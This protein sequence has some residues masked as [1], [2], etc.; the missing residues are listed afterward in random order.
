[1]TTQSAIHD[2]T[3]PLCTTDSEYKTAGPGWRHYVCTTCGNFNISDRAQE[4]IGKLHSSQSTARLAQLSH[5]AVPP[6]T[7]MS[8]KS[9]PSQE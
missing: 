1:M 4:L 3:C 7:Q 6:S 5:G 9:I 8:L 2:A